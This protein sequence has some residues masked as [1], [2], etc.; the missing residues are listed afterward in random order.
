MRTCVRAHLSPLLSQ[1]PVFDAATGEPLSVEALEDALRAICEASPKAS[2]PSLL[3]KGSSPSLAVLTT[4][5]RDEWA[6]LRASL[7]AH[8]PANRA[9]LGRI[10]DA[11]FCLSLDEADLG[12]EVTSDGKRRLRIVAPLRGWVSEKMLER[13]GPV[14]EE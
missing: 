14:P 5:E 6:R 9:S 2:A 11:L 8:A 13:E 3:S 12:G 7:E 10:D 1:L 4:C